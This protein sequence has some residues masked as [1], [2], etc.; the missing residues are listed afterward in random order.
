MEQTGP[1][2]AGGSAPC[3][4]DSQDE[5]QEVKHRPCH[6]KAAGRQEPGWGS[7]SLQDGVM[8]PRSNTRFSVRPAPPEHPDRPER[9]S[10]EGGGGGDQTKGVHYEGQQSLLAGICLPAELFWV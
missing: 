1:G 9:P 7:R 6:V 5:Q 4:N 3:A 10:L 8:R 2:A